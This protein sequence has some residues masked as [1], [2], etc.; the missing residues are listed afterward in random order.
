MRASIPYDMDIEM[1]TSLMLRVLP[2]MLGFRK[3]QLGTKVFEIMAYK[4][5]DVSHQLEG[6][7]SSEH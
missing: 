4:F 6:R 3:H 7:S 2:S 5:A 1:K